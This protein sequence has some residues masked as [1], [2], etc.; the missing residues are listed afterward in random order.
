LFRSLDR[1]TPC[2]NVLLITLQ[3]DEGFELS[4]EVKSPGEQFTL[5]TQRMQFRYAEAFGNL[6]TGYETLLL[7][8]MQ[9]DQTLFVHAD[10][11]EAAWKLYT[12]LLRKRPALHPYAAGGWGPA[13]ASRLVHATGDK[14]TTA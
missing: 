11:T 12:P 10:E 9:G 6:S 8:V 3:P 1:C 5:Q 2:G 13:A 7:E 14:W 4:F